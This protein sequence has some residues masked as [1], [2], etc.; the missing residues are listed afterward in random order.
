MTGETND[1]WIRDEN[2]DERDET[3]GKE[4]GISEIKIDCGVYR[5]NGI[6]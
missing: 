6:V 5:G 1:E 4:D 3:D 2:V